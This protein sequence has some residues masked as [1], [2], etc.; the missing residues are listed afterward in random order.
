MS[1]ERSLEAQ[2]AQARKLEAIGRLAGGVAHDFNNLLTA[3]SGYAEI[4]KA[5]LGADDPRSADVVEI[6]RAAARATQLTSQ[7]LAFGRRAIL[8]PTPLDPQ[9]V[10]TG[11]APMLRR[12]IGED[13]QLVV[14]AR[15]GLGPILADPS[16]LD[17]VLVNLAL[18]ARDAMPTGGRLDIDVLETD[19]DEEF[20]AAHVGAHAGRHV[21]IRVKDNGSGMK[22][23]VLE[24]AFDPFFTTK[25]PGK[26]TGLGLSTVLGIMEQSNGYLEVDS[27]PGRGTTFHLYLPITSAPGTDAAARPQPRPEIRASG[28]LLVV[29][30][31]GPVRAFLCR[32]LEKAGYTVLAAASGEQA[33]HVEAA[34]P[35]RID[36]LFTDVVLPGMSGRELAE[37]VKVRRPGIPVLYA[38]GY[39]QEIVAA[40][41]VLEPGIS[42]L[43]KPYTSDEV[44]RRLGELVR[45]SPQK[46]GN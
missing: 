16:Q 8:R 46:P 37:K 45:P 20:A 27:E 11:V 7:L 28:T 17:Q 35:G 25:G 29:E 10:V 14:Q 32:I 12:L 3:I 39:N 15:P 4:L 33:L 24:R 19:L 38:S 22:P 5:E 31:E 30:D 34:H 40:R 44:L 9:A 6:Q 23:E 18:N 26:G 1:R 41:G 21:V 36:L 42:Y 13:I 43:A 2:L